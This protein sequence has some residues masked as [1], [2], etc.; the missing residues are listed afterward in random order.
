M[1]LLK[2]SEA[3]VRFRG[4]AIG[5]SRRLDRCLRAGMVS[6]RPFWIVVAIGAISRGG[7]GQTLKPETYINSIEG[8]NNVL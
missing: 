1:T 8:D 2:H 7:A 3:R 6:V 5:L 4:R